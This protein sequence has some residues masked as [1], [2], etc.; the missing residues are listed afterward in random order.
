[1][2]KK[3][4]DYQEDP[5]VR[6]KLMLRISKFVVIGALLLVAYSAVMLWLR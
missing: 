1:M 3:I 2:F 4:F 5:K 6:E